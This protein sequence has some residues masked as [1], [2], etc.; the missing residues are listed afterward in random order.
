MVERTAAALIDHIEQHTAAVLVDHIEQHT[1]VVL[2]DHI[3]VQ[4]DQMVAAAASH[5]ARVRMK[6]SIA[7]EL[8]G[9]LCTQH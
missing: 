3:E 8:T 5:C 9:A 2:V 7:A 6:R 1:A 4:G